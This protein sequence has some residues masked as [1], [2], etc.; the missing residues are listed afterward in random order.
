[1]RDILVQDGF[2][3]SRVL[4]TGAP[5]L[6][7]GA[8]DL[9]PTPNPAIADALDLHGHFV[10]I[11][12]SGPGHRTTDEN[13]THTLEWLE[14]LIAK[15]PELDFVIKLHRKEKASAY[16]IFGS[17]QRKR[18]VDKANGKA[19]PQDIFEWLRGCSCLIT[20]T[21]TVAYEAMYWQ[22]PVISVDPLKE[23][24]GVNFIDEGVVEVVNTFEDLDSALLKV[25]GQGRAPEAF[26]KNIFFRSERPPAERI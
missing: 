19:L 11:A 16:S 7:S 12:L 4:V 21:S 22:I 10:L 18:I 6:A 3:Q 8:L 24:R 13:Y 2:E 1:F 9:N 17:N 5:Y 14:R 23:F 25:N 26:I 20:G 15:H